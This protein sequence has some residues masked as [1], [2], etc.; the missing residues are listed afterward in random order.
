MSERE[1]K[2]QRGEVERQR[3]RRRKSDREGEKSETEIPEFP[4][5]RAPALRFGSMNLISRVWVHGSIGERCVG[6]SPALHLGKRYNPLGYLLS[7]LLQKW[8]ET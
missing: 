4:K 3:R 5:P 6:S 1:N 8:F 2:G 7:S